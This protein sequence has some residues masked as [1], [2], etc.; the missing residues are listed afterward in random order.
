MSGQTAS[1]SPPRV[2]STSRC[3][4]CQGPTKVQRITPA[5]TG[6]EHWT[7]RCTEC[8]HINQ[9]QVVSGPSKSDPADWFDSE[10]YVLK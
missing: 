6:F 9:M 7:L 3:G 2:L 1:S 5:R 8:G 4:R 10:L